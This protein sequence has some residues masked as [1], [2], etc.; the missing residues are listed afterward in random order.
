MTMQLYRCLVLNNC[1]HNCCYIL[2]MISLLNKEIN[3]KRKY[4]YTFWQLWQFVPFYLSGLQLRSDNCFAVTIS[5]KTL[6]GLWYIWGSWVS[7]T[8]WIEPKLCPESLEYCQ[9]MHWEENISSETNNQ[10]QTETSSC[11]EMWYALYIF[12][13][14]YNYTYMCKLIS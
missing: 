7:F 5:S 2:G 11:T 3:I 9:L 4:Y 13:L 6:L 12:R 10:Y 14:L 1:L 8:L